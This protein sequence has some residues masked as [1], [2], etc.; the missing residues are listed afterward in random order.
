MR[1]ILISGANSGIGL[2]IAHK[3][4]QEGN[5]VSVGV[6]DLDSLEGSIIDPQKWPKEQLISNKY[7]ALDEN[8]SKNWISNTVKSFGSF[9]TL[10]NCAGILS[11]ASYLFR[12]NCSLGQ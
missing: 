9:D 8:S 12:I 6:R 1:T 7:D 5:R 4:L 10:I 3:Q 2:E 11:K